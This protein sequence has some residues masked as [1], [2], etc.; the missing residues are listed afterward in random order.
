MIT[1]NIKEFMEH[2]KFDTKEVA[3]YTNEEKG[4]IYPLSI[5][6]LLPRVDYL[7][8]EKGNP[9]MAGA[10]E[11][12]IFEKKIDNK[13]YK[14]VDIDKTVSKYEIT[15]READKVVLTTKKV[16]GACIYNVSN[17]LGIHTTLEDKEEAFKLC[18]DIRKVVLEHLK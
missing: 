13:D 7:E 5:A 14:I 1:E 17:Q 9:N 6:S 16:K 12:A 3:Y 8:L 18:E 10:L 15:K 2:I 11:K 4:L